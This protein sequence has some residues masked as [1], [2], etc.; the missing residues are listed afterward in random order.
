MYAVVAY[1]GVFGMAVGMMLGDW[2]LPFAYNETIA[3]FDNAVL[4]WVLLGGM[5]ALEMI[6]REV[7]APQLDAQA[8]LP[9]ATRSDFA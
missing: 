8:A 2:A 5:V 9:V 4:T 3:G 6:G 1:S 7:P